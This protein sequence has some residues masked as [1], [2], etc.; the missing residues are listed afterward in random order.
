[1]AFALR[2]GSFVANTSTGN[3]T[4]SLTSF[5][6]NTPD[7][8]MFMSAGLTAAGGS[9]NAISM[10]SCMT[11]SE[12]WAL[13]WLNRHN[14]G[15]VDILGRHTA[16]KCIHM[17]TTAGAT[18][19]EAQFVSFGAD[20]FVINWTDAPASA[21]LIQYI[22]ISGIQAYAWSDAVR[23]TT[24]TESLTGFG[25]Q[26][27]AVIVGSHG[28]NNTPPAFT[29]QAHALGVATA[30]GER[31]TVTVADFDGASSAQVG[32]ATMEKMLAVSIG[33]NTALDWHLELTSFDSD[34][35]TYEVTDA[36]SAGSAD[37][38]FGLA[39]GG[40]L[41]EAK[42]VTDTQKT[43]TGTKAKTGVGFEPDGM[44]VLSRQNATSF[45]TTASTSD[46]AR[47]VIGMTDA[48]TESCIWAA[49]EDAADPTDTDRNHSTT[50][51]LT[52][53]DNT[54]STIAEADVT[55]TGADG[56]T[57]DWTTADG[58]ARHFIVLALGNIG[59]SP[60]AL[61]DGGAIASAEAFGTGLV[62]YNQ[63]LSSGGAI[64]SEEAFGVGSFPS[65]AVLADGGGIV[66][67]EAFGVGL[68]SVSQ[69]LTHG[70]GI[71]SAEAFGSYSDSVRF[72]PPFGS[73]QY[74][75]WLKW[76]QDRNA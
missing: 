57:L 21:I 45:D 73:V 54:R 38:W 46:D 74:L 63:A 20:Q 37:Y 62:G 28:N 3:Q 10:F 29:G 51:F 43:S 58:T 49:F 52:F 13:S 72:S 59:A 27:K 34:G 14:L 66:T 8:V 11:D 70:G 64:A 1:M 67:A 65:N 35:I 60:Q 12:Q 48:T 26:P 24:G 17:L 18:D 22:A 6:G 2:H 39:L 47:M 50:K 44:V 16:S 68:V 32:T 61:T 76:L 9:D 31:G 7:V 23:T 53:L 42:V 36:P 30:A 75:R 33:N 5:G 25:F 19:G 56:Y 40:S 4:V 15:N 69:G 55:A 41:L 71:P